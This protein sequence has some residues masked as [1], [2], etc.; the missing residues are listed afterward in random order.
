LVSLKAP[1]ARTGA[2]LLA[3]MEANRR[4]ATKLHMPVYLFHGDADR[5]TDPAGSREIFQGLVR[6]G[7]R[8]CVCGRAAATKP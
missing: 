1:P 4:A 2:E 6:R 7:T 8:S 3:A 5:L